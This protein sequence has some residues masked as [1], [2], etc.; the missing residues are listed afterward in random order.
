MGTTLSIIVGYDYAG[1][2]SRGAVNSSYLSSPRVERRGSQPTEAKRR[3]RGEGGGRN[4]NLPW[5]GAP[6]CSVVFV[7]ASRLGFNAVSNVVFGLIGSQVISHDG[8]GAQFT[9]HFSKAVVR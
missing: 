5:D 6:F 4:P 7:L 9:R 3:F 2:L 8:R 1:T